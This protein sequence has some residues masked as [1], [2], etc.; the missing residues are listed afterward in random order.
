MDRHA[1]VV[2]ATLTC[3]YLEDKLFNRLPE[4]FSYDSINFLKNDFRFV[5]D[6]KYNW[7]KSTNIP[8]LR[9]LMN[10]LHVDIK[11]ICNNVSTVANFLDISRS[12]K[13]D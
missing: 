2:Y 13:N 8:P 10:N 11:Y 12:I 9:E 3:A 6:M 4:I 7:K 1:A 5:D